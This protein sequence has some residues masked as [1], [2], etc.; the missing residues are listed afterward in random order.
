MREI[1]KKNKNK[2]V[3]HTSIS[4]VERT[5]AC[6]AALLETMAITTDCV[7]ISF[8]PPGTLFIYKC[9]W[10]T[11][12]LTQ[13]FIQYVFTEQLL[14]TKPSYQGTKETKNHFCPQDM[15]TKYSNGECPG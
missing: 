8:P 13:S 12:S 6:P 1:K 2:S 10:I 15:E 14:N 4:T 5:S 7:A 3:H 11:Y 9:S